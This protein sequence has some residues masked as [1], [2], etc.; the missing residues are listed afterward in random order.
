MVEKRRSIR[1]WYSA[2][3][4]RRWGNGLE[5]QTS[6]L[7]THGPIAWTTD[8]LATHNDASDYIQPCASP[9]NARGRWLT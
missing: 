7:I 8:I 2:S 4:D 5:A 6:S 9:S 1:Q 3:V